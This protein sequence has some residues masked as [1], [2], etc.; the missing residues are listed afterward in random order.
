MTDSVVYVRATEFPQRFL[1]ETLLPPPTAGTEQIYLRSLSD[2]LSK[3]SA[4]PDTHS[5]Y[6]SSFVPPGWTGLRFSDVISLPC[7][8]PGWLGMGPSSSASR[9]LHDCFQAGGTSSGCPGP[10]Q[11]PRCGRVLEW[12]PAAGSST[13]TMTSCQQ[14][15]EAR[16]VL[17]GVSYER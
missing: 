11:S 5:S 15:G 10:K 6:L 17:T 9:T 13:S 4:H 7:E 3:V 12:Q 14:E 1:G 16:L 8:G 2:S